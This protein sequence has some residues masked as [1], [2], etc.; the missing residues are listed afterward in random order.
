M[1]NVNSHVQDLK[2]RC[3]VHFLRRLTVHH[4]RCQKKSTLRVIYLLISLVKCW[5]V[6]LSISGHLLF[7]AWRVFLLNKV[8]YRGFLREQ[9]LSLSLGLY[10]SFYPSYSLQIYLSIYL[11][12][13]VSL[14]ISDF[15]SFFLF[16]F[17]FYKVSFGN[18]PWR[19]A[20]Q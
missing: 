5:Y 9:N 7:I 17:P 10:L 13:Y 11:S 20:C 16:S 18:K 15:L 4:K 8:K 2:P 3:C 14:L 1:L 6:Y 19:L 12:I